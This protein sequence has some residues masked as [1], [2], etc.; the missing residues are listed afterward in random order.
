MRKK[1]QNLGNRTIRKFM[2]LMFLGV[3]TTLSYGQC[4]DPP[5]VDSEQYFCSATAWLLIGESADYLSDLQVFPDQV[6]WSI[7]WYEDNGGLPG[8]A[9]ANPSAELLVTGAVYHVTQ[10]DTANCESDP[11][12][13][14]LT[15]RDC[16]CIKDPTFEDQDGS[17]SVRGYEFKQFPNVNNH[18]T[19][20]QSMQGANPYTLG[21]TNGMA[22]GDDAVLV[23]P[24]NDPTPNV[25]V[26]RTNQNNPASSHGIRLNRNVQSQ[27]VITSMSK[28]FIAGEV[29]VFNFS[30]IMD[31]PGGANPHTYQQ[32]PFAQV[33]LYDMNDNVVQ[34]RCMVSDVNDCVFNII[35][36]GIT[37]RVWSEWSCMK[38]NTFDYIG[39]PLRAEFV[40]AY[41]TLTQH[42]AY[43]YIDDIYVGDDN[44]TICGNSSFGY[45]LVSSINAAGGECFIPEQSQ[46]PGSCASSITASIPGFPLEVCGVYDAPI[47]QGPPPVL[48]DIKMNIIQNDIIVGTVT[49][50]SG[51]SGP[52]TFC[53][54]I[55]ETDINVLPYGDFSFEIELDFELDCGDPYNFYI[56][57]TTSASVS[58]RA[59]CPKE[60]RVC[61]LDGSGTSIFDLTQVAS[62]IYNLVWDANDMT[63]SYYETEQD[64]HDETNPITPP[65][66]YQ[67]T[68]P[69]GQT[70]YVRIDWTLPE[71]P[72]NPYYLAPLELAIDILPDLSN[73]E[74]D[75]LS[76]NSN[77][78]FVLS[79][80]PANISD[81]G[82]VTYRWFKNGSQLASSASFYNVSEPGT[83]T[84]IVSNFGCES[85]HTF[86]V[87]FIELD[88]DLGQ[89]Q[90]VCDGSEVTL[91]ADLIPGPTT[92]PIDMNEVTFVWNTG[93][94]T[95]TITVSQSGYYTVEVRYFDC[96]ITKTIEIKIGDLQVDLGDDIILPCDFVGD[97][98]LTATVTGVPLN[99]VTYLWN[100]GE[101]TESITVSNPGTYSVDVFWN[102][103]VA[104]D[105]VTINYGFEVDLGDTEIVC[106]GSDVTITA[107][108]ITDPNAPPIDLND[109][110]FLWNTGETTQSITVSESG[111]YTV[112]VTYDG[113]VKTKSKEV[114]IGD[115]EVNLGEDIVL[116][117]GSEETILT[118]TVTGVPEN[119][120]TYLWSTGETTQ[121]ITVTGF[122]TY[123]VD[124][125]W[126]GC[127]VTDSITVSQ[128]EA[129]SISLGADFQKCSSET[130]TLEVNFIEPVTGNLTYTWL[131]D[132]V[133]IEG[134][135]SS[136]PITDFGVYTVIVD[137][138]GCIAEATVTV[139]AYI[140]NPDCII[141]QGISPE[142]SPGYND[143][144]DLE[145][146][147]TRTGIDKLQIFNRNGNLVYEYQNYT[148][149]WEGQTTSGDKLPTG[150]YYYVLSLSGNDP[151]YG[152]QTSGWIY[153]NRGIN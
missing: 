37:A 35:G 8:A 16:A 94:T 53:F 92:P 46:L 149:Q 153:L 77:V 82:D 112:D 152:P 80:V 14:T 39:Q 81:L 26:T 148:N 115:L 119:E 133:S 88:V 45:A 31:N 4:P 110:S 28:T 151:V 65:S 9:I 150:V 62:D 130:V 85:T 3:F 6:G 73:L 90:V 29:F 93:D 135:D 105:S 76:C 19:C 34:Q 113:C 23:T 1:I 141:S 52:N 136:L 78:G 27:D 138:E 51:G 43:M 103:C 97:T 108:L 38:L 109:V 2:P 137:N 49:N 75:Y 61:D 104:S 67:N 68:V 30:L 96:V 20:G 91:T 15:E 131:L 129:P 25:N 70:V 24:G 33:R 146:L 120:V 10:T 145:F 55:N 42:I 36:S 126:N 89:S 107:N 122:S 50:P 18:K 140:S 111:I 121:S 7:T 12:M 64:A 118:A 5:S 142:G 98:T 60:L 125:T 79:G 127:I 32:M 40:T 57:D 56:D 123:S 86:T 13:I 99:E 21:N 48:D 66:A 95:Q 128:G 134:S 63:L 114:M 116:C 44:N 87:D 132:G 101:T 124:V 117:D 17:A 41:C 58:P 71:L 106:D 72:S 47:S 83:Y 74:D 54:T 143:Y 22:A 69:G 139:S 84:V 102:G 11:L 100:T 144:L 147:S 59:G